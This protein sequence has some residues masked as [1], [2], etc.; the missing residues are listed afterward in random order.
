[1][2]KGRLWKAKEIKSGREIWQ[3]F[4]KSRWCSLLLILAGYTLVSGF[5]IGCPIRYITGF[6]C[7]GC[8]M[9]RAFWSLFHG[10]I[11]AAFSYHPLFFL[12]P[13]LFYSIYQ[14]EEKEKNSSRLRFMEGKGL[15]FLCIILFFSV[16]I[17]RMIKGDSILVPDFEKS[18]IYSIKNVVIK[19]MEM[20]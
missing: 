2:N 12:V 15:L 19:V 10:N 9:T 11:Q 6:S 7:P 1:M 5:T 13:V 4:K 18:L 14:V 16:W 8:G 17:F 3:I 20:L